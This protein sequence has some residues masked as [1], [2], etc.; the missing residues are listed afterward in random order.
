[1]KILRDRVVFPKSREV[2]EDKIRIKSYDLKKVRDALIEE[3]GGLCPLCERDLTQLKAIQRT[4]DHN[5]VKSGPGAGA[6]RGALCSNCN[7]N[8]GRIRRRVL[9]SKGSMDEIK[10]LSNLVAY[11]DKHKENFTGLIHYKHKTADELREIRNK[12]QRQRRAAK[13]KGKK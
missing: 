11:W 12:K 1:M 3:Q 10:W 7:G 13:K 8:E 5:H 9:S 4:V 6:V 2:I